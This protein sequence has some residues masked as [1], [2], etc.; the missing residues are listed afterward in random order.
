MLA[1]LARFASMYA[2]SLYAATFVVAPVAALGAQQSASYI[3][4]AARALPRGT[5]LTAGDIASA[6]APSLGAVPA[7]SP[8]AAGWV[9]RRMVRAGEALRAPAVAP[10]PLFA[11]NHPVRFVVKRAG[12][13][14]SIDGV[15]LVAA[16]L[17][18]T[19]PVRLGAKRRMTGVVSGPDEVVALDSLRNP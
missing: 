10:A 13:Q 7:E 19:V 3:A 5:V 8:V 2:C 17:G 6:P 15:A 12:F 1:R 14:M 16:S 4:V 9:T 18:D 11:A